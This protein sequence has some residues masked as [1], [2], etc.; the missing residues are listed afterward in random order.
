MVHL[1]PK[2][3]RKYVRSCDSDVIMVLCE[4]LHNVLLGHV[5]VKVRDIEKYSSQFLNDPSVQHTGAQLPFLNRMR[6]NENTFKKSTNKFWIQG[7]Q[8]ILLSCHNYMRR[9]FTKVLTC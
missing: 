8:L 9:K 5:R 1:Q 7:K 3:L 6:P 4:C 2:Q